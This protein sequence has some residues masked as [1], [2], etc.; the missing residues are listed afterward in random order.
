MAFT[1]PFGA[2][3]RGLGALRPRIEA[4]LDPAIVLELDDHQG[5]AANYPPNICDDNHRFAREGRFSHTPRFPRQAL[6]TKPGPA[7]RFAAPYSDDDAMTDYLD[8]WQCIGCGRMEAPR[9]CVGVCQDRKVRLVAAEDYDAV[10]ERLRVATDAVAL[11]RLLAGARPHAE[12]WRE[13]FEALQAK[14]RALLT[15]AADVEEAIAEQAAS[16]GKG[17]R[18]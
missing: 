13:S 4:E 12:R 6:P 17:D 5:K 11:L 18:A 7:R 2:R 16:T 8:A 9:P 10:V 1:A 14:A 3:L 15:D